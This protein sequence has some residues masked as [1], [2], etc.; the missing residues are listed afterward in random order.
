MQRESKPKF[1][2]FRR[3]VFKVLSLWFSHCKLSCITGVCDT[4]LIQQG[5]APSSASLYS[6][7]FTRAGRE[8]F[9]RESFKLASVR[10]FQLSNNNNTDFWSSSSVWAREGM[11]PAKVFSGFASFL[12]KELFPQPLITAPQFDH[13]PP[14]SAL[15]CSQF[16]IRNVAEK[17]KEPR[18]VNWLT[19]VLI[20]K[21]RRH[22]VR[23]TG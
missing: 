17:I 8:F 13:S 9:S 23:W 12:S 18:T 5:Q 4:P 20:S 15:G 14:H 19:S 6:T 21:E 16:P 11:S 10:L 2:L 1:L 3:A 7:G 22:Q